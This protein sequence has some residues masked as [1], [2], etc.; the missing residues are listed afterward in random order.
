[1]SPVANDDVG[2]ACGGVSVPGYRLFWNWTSAE[3]AQKTDEL[4]AKSRVVY[5][6]IGDLSTKPDSI[7]VDSVLKVMGRVEFIHSSQ[8]S[9]APSILL[10]FIPL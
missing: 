10:Y 9:L 5:D 2:P 8:L 3:I 4:I 1:M 6:K 7:T